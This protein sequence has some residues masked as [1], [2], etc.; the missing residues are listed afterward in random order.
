MVDEKREP[1]RASAASREILDELMDWSG[2]VFQKVREEADSLSTKGKLKIDITTLKSRRGSEFKKLGEKVH[3]L[4]ENANFDVSE[5]E[6]NIARVDQLTEEIR[7]K[8][9]RLKDLGR[10]GEAED[11]PETGETDDAAEE[12]AEETGD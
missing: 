9:S 2:K 11:I 12:V 3:R 6:D 10:R 4:L 5:I 1:R 7:E 8:E